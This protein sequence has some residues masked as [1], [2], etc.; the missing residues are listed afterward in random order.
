MF[1]F[2]FDGILLSKHALF[3]FSGKFVCPETGSQ[4]NLEDIEEKSMSLEF[5]PQSLFYYDFFLLISN[6]P[7]K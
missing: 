1:A 4:Q 2:C 3:F 7:K 6:G 5:L